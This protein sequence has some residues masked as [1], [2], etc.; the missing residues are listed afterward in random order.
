MFSLRSILLAAAAFA[1]MTSAIPM[2]ET[3]T[4]G[5][6]PNVAGAGGAGGALGTITD[7][8][9]GASNAGSATD[10]LK[11]NQKSLA[12]SFQTCHGGIAAVIVEIS[13]CHILLSLSVFMVIIYFFFNS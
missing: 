9:S 5:I 10:N 12:D 7:I 4:T 1:T 6:T 3:G 13:K 8:V 2:P 11:R